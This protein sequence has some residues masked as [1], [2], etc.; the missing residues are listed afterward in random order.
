MAAF[1]RLLELHLKTRADV[2]RRS[3]D[4]AT[5]TPLREMPSEDVLL[6]L[7]IHCKPEPG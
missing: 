3:F 7:V 6:L 5:L 4:R 2:V 1:A